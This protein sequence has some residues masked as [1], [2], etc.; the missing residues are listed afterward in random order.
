MFKIF[1]TLI[2]DAVFSSMMKK[3]WNGKS[4]SSTFELIFEPQFC[5]CCKVKRFAESWILSKKSNEDISMGV[6]RR[7]A[8]FKFTLS[9]QISFAWHLFLEEKTALF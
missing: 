2:K 4:I 5:T 9:V 3:S 6:L 7:A 1:P 8:H